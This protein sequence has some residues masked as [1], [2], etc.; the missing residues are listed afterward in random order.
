M[1]LFVYFE[2]GV[3]EVND[4]P[5]F[6]IIVDRNAHRF[7][8]LFQRAEELFERLE[9]VKERFVDLCALGSCDIEQ[10]VGKHCQI[11]E[12]WDR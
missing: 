4:H 7:T 8:Q 2:Q 9:K 6:P 11:A 3:S 1:N 10:L 12:D 5:V